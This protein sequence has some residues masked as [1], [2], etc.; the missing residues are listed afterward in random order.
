MS[1]TGLKRKRIN[2]CNF[3]V[4]FR[5]LKY[6]EYFISYARNVV[7]KFVPTQLRKLRRGYEVDLHE[8]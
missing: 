5:F 7:R 1:A 6:I 4:G 8:I 2:Y 3:K